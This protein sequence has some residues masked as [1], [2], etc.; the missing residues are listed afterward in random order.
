MSA[1]RRGRPW[2][3]S[4]VVPT[5]GL[6]PYLEETLEA[7]A[8]QSG[9]PVPGPRGE[10]AL[11]VVL[12]RP[13]SQEAG[14]GGDATGAVGAPHRLVETA[15]E[16]GFAPAVNR[17][18]A[19]ALEGEPDL[20][21]MVNDDLIV[22]PGWAAELVQALESRPGAVAAQGLHLSLDDP[23][24]IDGRGLAWNRWWQA[25][26]LGHGEATPG[27]ATPDEPAPGTVALPEPEEIFGVSGTAALFQPRALSRLAPSRRIAPPGGPFDPDL[28]S[29]YEDVELACRLRAAGG[30]ALSVPRARARHAGSATGSRAAVDRWRLIHGNRLLVLARLLGRSFLPLLP[31]IALRDVLDLA[32]ALGRADSRRAL[33]VVLGWARAARHL[34]RF[35]RRGR[36]LVPLAELER[37]R[38]SSRR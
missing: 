35:L 14:V 4:V 36:P 3:V 30:V 1:Q 28:G 23:S 25:V 21:G 18:L 37:F 27:E 11:E 9:S 38:V 2:R 32:A 16:E 22:E 8:T 7:L 31:R 29:W 33:G 12:V 19:A 10:V 5:L 17:G 24:R 15:G 34:H 26:Q 6:S 13:R 20:V